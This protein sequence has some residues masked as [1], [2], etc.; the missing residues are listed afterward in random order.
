MSG[1]SPTMAKPGTSNNDSPPV[2]TALTSSFRPL[3]AT[4]KKLITKVTFTQ[5][6]EFLT[7]HFV[8]WQFWGRAAEASLTEKSRALFYWFLKP[9]RLHSS[10]VILSVFHAERKPALSGVEGDLAR[11]AGAKTRLHYPA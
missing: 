1:S 11:I 8:V 7:I 5:N 2:S 4:R 6:E 3:F 9:D 10:A